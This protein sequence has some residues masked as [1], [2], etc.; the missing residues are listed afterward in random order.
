[1]PRIERISENKKNKQTWIFGR[2]E[3][4]SRPPYYPP[5]IPWIKP[6][7][8]DA[9]K[10][11]II[12]ILAGSNAAELAQLNE[13]KATVAQLDTG[14][15]M[16][17]VARRKLLAAQRKVAELEKTTAGINAGLE[18]KADRIIGAW[19]M[20]RGIR[21]IHMESRAGEPAVRFVTCPIAIRSIV[22]G[23]YDFWL[24]MNH[25]APGDVFFLKRRDRESWP[26]GPHPHWGSYGCFG[27]FGPLFER[28]IR[29]NEWAS[30]VGVFMQYLAIYFPGS[31]L[32]RIN[33]FK[34][35][36]HWNEDPLR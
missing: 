27:T 34:Q 24:T 19:N 16:T 32:I 36:S 4:D 7:V 12:S 15:F 28:M 26:Q 5:V 25:R 13:A 30:I 1:M 20:Q 6:D 29:R 35:R 11:Y 23:T 22:L 33:N 8:H 17:P 9:L 18:K 31:P 14:D 3:S 2:Y 10:R 21:E